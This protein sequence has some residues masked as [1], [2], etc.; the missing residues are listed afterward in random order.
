M[1]N[2]LRSSFSFRL[3]NPL[4]GNDTGGNPGTAGSRRRS[5]EMVTLGEP[6]GNRR[7]A[8]INRRSSDGALHVL[9]NISFLSDF[10]EEEGPPGTIVDD[11]PPSQQRQRPGL[12]S[13]RPH[14][15]PAMSTSPLSSSQPQPS[16]LSLQRSELDEEYIRLKIALA[17][18]RERTDIQKLQVRQLMKERDD[19]K[20]E[21]ETTRNKTADQK[22]LAQ[23]TMQV[24]DHLRQYAEEASE[25]RD[26]LR[27]TAERIERERDEL[28]KKLARLEEEL[29]VGLNGDDE[30]DE[31]V[32]EDQGGGGG[33]ESAGGGGRRRPHRRAGSNDLGAIVAAALQGENP[34]EGGDDVEFADDDDAESNENG[35]Q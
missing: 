4:G 5:E 20:T 23:E 22:V 24:T 35:E 14:S 32:D 2:M 7:H 19:L 25:E 29:G 26:R 16:D 28:K 3:S 18:A 15:T 10:V 13:Y 12:S 17:E 27:E 30:D 1:Q 8:P 6:T 9:R 31:D 21:L 11:P 34:N 33:V